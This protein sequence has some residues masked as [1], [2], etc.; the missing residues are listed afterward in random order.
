MQLETGEEQYQMYKFERLRQ[1]MWFDTHDDLHDIS[2]SRSPTNQA[3]LRRTK[4][5]CTLGSKT[6]TIVKSALQH[7]RL[8]WPN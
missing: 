6:A 2:P 4:I 3:F 5:M 8:V 7:L 1:P